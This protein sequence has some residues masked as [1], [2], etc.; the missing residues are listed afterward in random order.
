MSKLG[1]V[2]NDVTPNCGLQH[3]GVSHGLEGVCVRKRERNRRSLL[4]CLRHGWSR[5]RRGDR[6][7]RNGQ[8]SRKAGIQVVDPA[9]QGSAI[10]WAVDLEIEVNPLAWTMASASRPD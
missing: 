7:E 2:C 3:K 6:A 9:S 8:R 1:F 5:A 10:L 4:G